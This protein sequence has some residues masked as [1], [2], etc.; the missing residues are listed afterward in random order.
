MTKP[1]LYALR[2]M[3]DADLE[4]VLAWRNSERVRSCMFSDQL[5]PLE[6]HRAWWERA[7]TSP[8]SVHL[9]FEKEGVPMGVVNFTAIDRQNGRCSWGF[10]VGPENTP[11]GTGTLMGLLAID[12]AFGTLGM[13]KICAEV[14]GFNTASL[15]YHRK[16]G[17]LQEGRLAR[18]V[19][20]GNGYEDVV[21]FALFAEDW[22]EARQ[23][24]SQY[25]VQEEER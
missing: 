4:R 24:L 25:L 13:R 16:L 22:P 8:T 1:N 5:I 3:A 18:H 17:F 10:Y 20:R 2:P 11:R 9:I 14:I 12:Y 7:K 21:L 19:L 15:G 6:Q 23:P